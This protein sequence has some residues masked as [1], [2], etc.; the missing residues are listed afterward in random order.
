MPAGVSKWL[1]AG[2][3]QCVT[4]WYGGYGEKH[5]IANL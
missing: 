1:T 5:T 2:W 4:L 3:H